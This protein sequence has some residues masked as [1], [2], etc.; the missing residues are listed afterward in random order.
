MACCSL[1]GTI[2]IVLDLG[3]GI[4]MTDD[5]LDRHFQALYGRSSKDVTRRQAPV[6]ENSLVMRYTHLI[7]QKSTLVDGSILP[8]VGIDSNDNSSN[9][10]ICEI[11]LENG[12]SIGTENTYATVGPSSSSSSSSSIPYAFTAPSQLITTTKDGKKRISPLQPN[13]PLPS[14]ATVQSS[15]NEHVIDSIAA[16]SMS[17][18]MDTSS[19]PLKRTKHP[20]TEPNAVGLKMTINKRYF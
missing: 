7:T 1:D 5:Q 17:T 18:R 13:L 12:T 14:S 9:N 11:P 3:L 2:T 8:I 10:I 15:T 16:Y 19:Q 4:P 6:A 20:I